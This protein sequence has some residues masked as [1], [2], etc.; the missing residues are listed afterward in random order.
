[1]SVGNERCADQMTQVDDDPNQEVYARKSLVLFRLE[2]RQ[3]R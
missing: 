3:G 1:M 2:R